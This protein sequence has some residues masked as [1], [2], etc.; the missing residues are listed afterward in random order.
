[1]TTRRIAA[2]AHEVSLTGSPMN[3]LHLLRWISQE[4]DTEVTTIV[5]RDGP[6]RHRF[7]EV[8]PVQVLDGWAVPAVLRTVQTGLQHLG[9][10]RAWRPVAAARLRP[11]LRPLGRFD[12]VYCNSLP[13]VPVL[14]YLTPPGAVVAHVHELQVAYRNWHAPHEIELFRTVPDR[15]IAASEAV[16]TMLVDEIELPAERVDLH[17]EFIDAAAIVARAPS[18][19]EIDA[20]RREYR[21]PADAAVVVGAGTVDWRKGP[22]L[23]VQLACEVRRR[24]RE[25]VQF[26]WVGG[27]LRSPDWER[28]RSDRDRA[29]ADHVHF[30]GVRPDPIPW[31]ALADVF[32]LTSREDPYPL[33]ALECAALGKPIVTYRNGGL[34][35]LL[36]AA[37]P[38]A[39]TGIVDHLDVGAMAERILAL[40]DTERLRRRAGEQLRD[41]TFAAHDVSRAAPGLWADLEELMD[42]QPRDRRLAALAPAAGATL[43]T[44]DPGVFPTVGM[45]VRRPGRR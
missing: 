38:E 11:Q 10:S 19:R 4:T 35:E 20:C 12:L 44:P 32:A 25:P 34:P 15:W 33:V 18:L 21:I 26:V 36:V 43:P 40:L 45:G 8:G 9:S 17:H 3:L 24:T 5:L 1:M 31:F 7:E 13:S 42:Q 28:V 41:R 37:G 23:F 27:D 16:R 6:L 29:G 2:V 14:P 30:V 22:D 39:A